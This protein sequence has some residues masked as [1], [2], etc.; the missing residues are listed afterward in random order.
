MSDYVPTI[1]DLRTKLCF[2]CRE[3]ETCDNPA[4][5]PPRKWTHPCQCMLIAHEE[6][7]LEWIKTAQTKSTTTAAE[8]ALKC[9]QCGAKYQLES[10]LPFGMKVMNEALIKWNVSLGTMG[11]W[12]MVAIP[13]GMV[14]GV[15]IGTHFVLTQYGAYAFREFCGDELFNALL[16]TDSK[17]WPL[18]SFINLPLIPIGL[19]SYRF[20]ATY[21]LI[22][23]MT[24][25]LEWPEIQRSRAHSLP[26]ISWPPS[27]FTVG[28]VLLPLTRYLYAE[29]LQ[30]VTRLVLK[31]SPSRELNAAIEGAEVDRMLV[32]RFRHTQGPEGIPD[33]GGDDANQNPGNGGEASL[34]IYAAPLGRSIGGALLIPFIAKR[35]GT[36]LLRL[37]KY[38]ELLR[39]FLAVR[40]P[41]VRPSS[42]L[43]ARSVASRSF[44]GG[45]HT[46]KGSEVTWWDFLRALWGGGGAWAEFD[47]VW[48][49]NTIGFG[50][51]IIA[52]DAI[53][54]LH[55]YLVKKE[56]E[57]RRVK[58]RDFR[59]VDV[60]G[61]NLLP[62]RQPS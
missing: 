46:G 23:A 50:T 22:S 44:L 17:K 57:T 54:L 36:L 21:T 30:R 32:V 2:I 53:H 13:V 59:D 4:E 28:F 11:K 41:G 14:A 49:R 19:V 61:L 62:R 47:S 35:M 27:P 51:F 45:G 20:N 33:E 15:A 16:T 3:E 40:T 31:T 55:L 37:S 29:C 5:D 42:F 60:S 48:W 38:S 25:L 8:N 10:D 9:P 1:D 39:R 6:C 26:Q 7:L 43:K 56:F 12:F 58:S 24:T 18:A 52:K 34:R